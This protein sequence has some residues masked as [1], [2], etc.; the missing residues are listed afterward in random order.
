MGIYTTAFGLSK[1]IWGPLKI[2]SFENMATYFRAF[3]TTNY[4]KDM[5]LEMPIYCYIN[6]YIS[7]IAIQ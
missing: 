1:S 7:F 6:L 3:P 2:P 5:F 4:E